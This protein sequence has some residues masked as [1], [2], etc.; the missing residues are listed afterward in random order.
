MDT[1]SREDVLYFQFDPRNHTFNEYSG[2]VVSIDDI[3]DL[4]LLYEDAET[5]NRKKVLSDA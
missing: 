3:N 4:E 1:V 2:N 5:E